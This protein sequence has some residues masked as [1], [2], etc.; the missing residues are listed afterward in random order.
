MAA[1]FGSLHSAIGSLRTEVRTGFAGID[2]RL[3]R[4]KL[5]L[6]VK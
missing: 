6:A 1:Q 3:D 4:Q 5:M 2:E